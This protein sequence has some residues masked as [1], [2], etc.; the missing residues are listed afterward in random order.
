M[1]NN[2]TLH[3]QDHRKI[4]MSSAMPTLTYLEVSSFSNLTNL[5]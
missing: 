2:F 3:V 1:L 5:H 4:L